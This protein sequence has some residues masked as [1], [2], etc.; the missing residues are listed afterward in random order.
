MTDT[1][2]LAKMR[3]ELRRLRDMAEPLP[4]GIV[5][6]IFDEIIEAIIKLEARVDELAGR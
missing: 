4:T 3:E 1:E 6:T 5:G 2:R